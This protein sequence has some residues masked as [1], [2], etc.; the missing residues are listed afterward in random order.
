MPFLR[1]TRRETLPDCMGSLQEGTARRAVC[2]SCSGGC[3]SY[4]EGSWLRREDRTERLGG[5]ES[6]EQNSRCR[7]G[8]GSRNTCCGLPVSKGGMSSHFGKR[9]GRFCDHGKN[10]TA[11][12]LR[13][14]GVPRSP[15]LAVT[16]G[17][18][19]EEQGRREVAIDGTG[20]SCLPGSNRSLIYPSSLHSRT[21]SGRRALP[22]WTIKFGETLVFSVTGAPPFSSPI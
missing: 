2:L 15:D 1:R 3:C 8:S 18:R 10:Q 14:T 9:H 7:S 4:R 19:H 21:S 20:R 13:Q 16:A 22:D 11:H 12:H 17:R 6:A 5:T